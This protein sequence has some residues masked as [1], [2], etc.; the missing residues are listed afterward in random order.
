MTQTLVL[1]PF[2]KQGIHC[3]KDPV[4]K[5]G[6]A[7]DYKQ[8]CSKVSQSRPAASTSSSQPPPPTHKSLT[9]SQLGRE[10]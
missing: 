10:I 1:E 3:P 7:S 6:P 5:L 2:Q 8:P 4:P 9:E